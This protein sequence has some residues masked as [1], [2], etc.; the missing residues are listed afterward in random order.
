MTVTHAS[1]RSQIISVSDVQWQDRQPGVRQ[2]SLWA[3]PATIRRAVMSRIE[4]NAQLPRHRHVGDELVF[5][6]E[7][8]NLGRVQN[9]DRR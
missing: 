2:K 8:A 1:L 7:G 5:V 6:I 9:R 3:D 4:S